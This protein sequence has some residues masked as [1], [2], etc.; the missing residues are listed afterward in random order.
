MA[1][2]RGLTKDQQD[3]ARAAIQTTQL[4]KRLQFFALDVPDPASGMVPALDSAKMRAIEV[5][6][7]KTLPDLQS[8]TV[9]GG[10]S[11]VKFSF[12]ASAKLAEMLDAI[13]SRVP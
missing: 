1:A 6:L 7:K 5:L 9:E 11:P 10:E 13:A 8:V 2:T 4:V 12:G 3:R